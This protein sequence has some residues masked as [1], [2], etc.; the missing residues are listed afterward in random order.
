MFRMIFVAM[1]IVMTGCASPLVKRPAANDVKKIAFI[2]VYSNASIYDIKNAKKTD[3]LNILGKVINGNDNINDENVQLSTFAL[4]HYSE[5]LSTKQWEVVNPSEILKH[6]AYKNFVSDAK[7]DGVLGFLNKL[8]SASW[9][10]PPG[11][12][13]FPYEAVVNKPG[14]YQLGRLPKQ[15]SRELLAQLSKQ[16]GV[17]GVGIV[18][19]DLAYKKP[20]MSMSGGIL[21]MGRGSAIPQISSEMVVVNSKGE[22]A[23]Q[24]SPVIKGGGERFKSEDKAPMLI[25][26]RVVLTGE[27]GQEAIGAFS[28]AIKKN[29][30][31]MKVKI[32]KELTKS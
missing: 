1:L 22:I 6:Q 26:G 14:P 8:E 15:K 2:S 17:D 31:A 5:H 27:E 28:E 21:G 20:F 24:T 11:M 18:Y 30:K 16:L 9:A 12:V 10:V 4:K 25:N 29:A 7:G 3:T 23:L 19:V 32:N 13:Y